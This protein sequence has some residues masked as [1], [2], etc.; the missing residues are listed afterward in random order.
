M[1]N[2]SPPPHP[3]HSSAHPRANPRGTGGMHPFEAPT[4]R[5]FAGPCA[6]LQLLEAAVDQANQDGRR[7]EHLLLCGPAGCGKQILARAVVR[8][9]AQRAVE[10]DG[11]GVDNLSH[12][13]E[14]VRSLRPRDVL[15]VRHLD[16]MPRRGQLHLAVMLTEHHAPRAARR[17]HEPFARHDPDAPREQVADFTLLGTTARPERVQPALW[18]Q[19]E[20]RIQLPA[21]TL[22]HQHAA[23]RRALTGLGLAID[24]RAHDALATLCA[25]N[26]DRARAIL[27]ATAIR[28]R[29]EGAC[30]VTPALVEQ[31]ARADLPLLAT[32]PELRSS[33]A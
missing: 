8:E 19:F 18:R 24:P 30:L 9:L 28:A 10:V 12:L 16:R 20:W 27:R 25:T 17:P 11:D 15:L 14:L 6:G 3:D 1:Q 26:A 2:S 5:S 32:R 7:L 31:C 13:M 23:V 4:I 22:E 21:P 33:T 29:A